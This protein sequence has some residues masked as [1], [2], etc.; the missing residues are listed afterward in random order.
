[1]RD[2]S[3]SYPFS[4]LR[5]TPFGPVALLWS[6]HKGVPKI[7]RIVLS[8]PGVSARDRVHN[9]FSGL[10]PS[11]FSEIDS[12]AERI[13]AFLEGE[14][15]RFSLDILLMDMCTVFQQ[16]VL[17]AEF[18]IP[19]GKV[20]TYQRIA[21]HSGYDKAARPVGSALARNP[22]PVVIPCHRAVRTDRTLGG[23][24]GGLEMKKALLEL[25]GVLFDSQGRVTPDRMYYR[26][27]RPQ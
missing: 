26:N 23:F 10:T 22:F 1:M 16:K 21:G 4:C 11:T 25:E 12:T 24:H 27:R 18:S 9:R 15:V 7:L 5:D 19:R 14:D 17:R 20:S 13:T 6:V 2:T 8:K 3:I